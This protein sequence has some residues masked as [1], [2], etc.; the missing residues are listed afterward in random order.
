[1]ARLHAQDVG[2]RPARR[3]VAWV[4]GVALL[5][6]GTIT[7]AQ[8]VEEPA[9]VALTGVLKRIKAAGVVRLGY[10][11][12]AVPFSFEGSGG[13]PHGYSIDLC[14]EIVDELARTVGSGSLRIEYRRVTP[15]DRIAQVVDGGIDLECGATT[16]TAERRKQVAFSPLIFV[17]GTRLLVRHGSPVRSVRDLVGRKVVVVRGTTNEQ[18]MNQLAALR[19]RSFEVL[20]ADDYEQAL[21][22]LAAG[23]VD[24]LAADDI[25]L[26]GYIAE[27]GL[28]GRYA[29][30]GE[31]LSYEPY[32]I[33]FVRGDAPLAAAVDA[34]FRR[35]AASREI[36]WIYNKWFLR[37]LPSGI[38]LGLPMSAELQ[39]SF[40]VLGLPPD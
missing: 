5:A 30:V 16:N 36:R 33:M 29:V 35:L 39:R 4:V 32:G 18:A 23:E 6:A 3:L 34:A 20:A 12:D 25:L 14:Q 24:A 28:R 38:R 37:P 13:R 2:A 19:K 17:A 21:Q 7:T 27:K 1:M 8:P 10:R 40:E 26:T 9:A 15:A 22:K 31:L 11:Q